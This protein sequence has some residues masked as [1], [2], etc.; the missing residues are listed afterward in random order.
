MGGGGEFF[1]W[2]KW[3]A[4]WLYDDEVLCV[5][6]NNKRSIL[7]IESFQSP[8]GAKLIAVPVSSHKVILAEFRTNS[9][10]G[11]LNKFGV[12]QKNG[13]TQCESRY[14]HSGLLIYSLDTTIKHGAAPFRVAQQTGQPLLRTGE[15]LK[16]EG[17]EF[18][19]VAASE[20][21]I[22]VQVTRN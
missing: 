17:I 6:Q 4:G 5:G 7:K 22:Y 1:S 21:A 11:Y 18:Q 10:E 20:N 12:C 16:F 19:T 8:V 3:I 14:E 9:D 15:T 2:S 13:I